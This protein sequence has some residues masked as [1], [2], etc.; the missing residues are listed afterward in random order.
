MSCFDLGM[1]TDSPWDLETGNA[2]SD[3]GD[4]LGVRYS[5]HRTPPVRRLTATE[6]CFRAAPMFPSRNL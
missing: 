4:S 5:A 6:I 1:L 3:T 2:S